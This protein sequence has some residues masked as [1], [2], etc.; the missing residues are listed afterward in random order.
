MTE[1]LRVSSTYQ[2]HRVLALAFLALTALYYGAL[3][4]IAYRYVPSIPMVA[5]YACFLSLC[6]FFHAAKEGTLRK[7]LSLRDPDMTE[8]FLLKE[9]LRDLAARTGMKIPP[10][11]VFEGN[12]DGVAEC[13]YF[14][15]AGTLVLS[16][17]AIHSLAGDGLEFVIA[18]ELGHIRGKDRLILL[19]FGPTA[20]VQR[21]I[22]WMERKGFLFFIASIPLKTV[23][24]V[25]SL[26]TFLLMREMEF[27]A[28]AFAV[29][30][31]DRQVGIRLLQSRRTNDT[32]E[33]RFIRYR[34][35]LLQRS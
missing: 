13:A 22:G 19:S 11:R 31:T 21:Y 10:V 4:A 34:I 15:D 29:Q 17:T 2:T 26:I 20:Y 25:P 6:T 1:P 14:S 12:R 3:G 30:A 28:D 24:I 7:K 18:H 32:Y 33:E 8:A 5:G 9:D 23:V 35:A 27:A 16:Q